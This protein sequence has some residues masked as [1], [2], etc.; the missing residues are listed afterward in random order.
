MQVYNY[1]RVNENTGIFKSIYIVL[2]SSDPDP[3]LITGLS[4]VE[5]SQCMVHLD[6]AFLNREMGRRIC[7]SN[8]LEDDINNDIE[9]DAKQSVGN[10]VFAFSDSQPSL[11]G[12]SCFICDAEEECKSE[13]DSASKF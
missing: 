8:S 2:K 10:H 11:G 1:R 5:I 13:C 7:K 4:L 3:I 12:F 9:S 6:V